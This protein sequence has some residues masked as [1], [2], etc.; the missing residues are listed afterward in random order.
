MSIHYRHAIKKIFLLTLF[1]L[2]GCEFIPVDFAYRNKEFFHPSIESFEVNERCPHLCWLGIN[3]GATTVE[4]A[5]AILK[6]SNRIN[7]Q[8][9]QSSIDGR[10]EWYAGKLDTFRWSVGVPTKNGLV[11]S[12]NFG[13]GWAP[14]VLSDFI[15]LLGEPDEISIRV[16][17]PADAIYITYTVFFAKTNTRIF[18][19]VGNDHGPDPNDRVNGLFL[20]TDF[21]GGDFSNQYIELI[22]SQQPWKGYGHLKEYLP[23][24]KLP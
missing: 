13:N 8:S 3:P 21:Y 11:E 24:Q 6:S 9:L 23:D 16:E 4:E 19:N 17:R 5:N 7:Q 2:T 12:I 18:V 10:I 22:N 1:F 20:N 14:F 15:N